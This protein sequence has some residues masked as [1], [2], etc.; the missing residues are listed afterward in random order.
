VK[1]RTKPHPEPVGLFVGIEQRKPTPADENGRQFT[2]S[3]TPNQ[4]K[5]S[6]FSKIIAQA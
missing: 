5:L 2:V 1:S 3:P 6:V 4:D